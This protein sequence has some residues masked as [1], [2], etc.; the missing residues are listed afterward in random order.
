MKK[1]MNQSV[2]TYIINGASLLALLFMVFSLVSYGKVSG[3]LNKANEDRFNLT[4]NA[5][6]FMNGS[7]YLTNEV[8]AFAATGKQEH[9]DN[10]FNEINNLKN[11][12]LGV[13][14]MKEIGITKEEQEMI[15]QMSTLSNHLVPLEEQAMKNVKEG[16][17]EDAVGYVYGKEY[18]SA[19][20]EIN[21]IKERF[22]A[23]LD[24]RASEEVKLLT[25]EADA[26]EIRILF[27]LA[28][29]GIMQLFSM[30]VTRF[31]ILR[32]VITVKNQMGEISRGNLSAEFNLTS[33]TSEIGMLVASIHETKRELKK[34]IKD[35][36]SK[37]AQMAKG[38]MNLTIGDDYRGEFK[39]IQDAMREILDALNAALAQ[40]NETAE[41][42]AEESRRMAT[43]AQSLSSGTVEQA[44][45]VEQLSSSVQDIS[46][47][48]T[49]TSKDADDARRHSEDAASELEVCDQKMEALTTAMSDISKASHEIGGIIK[50]IEDISSQTNILALNASVE[51]AHAGDAGRGF[52]VVADEVQSLANKSSE[53]AQNI[54]ALIENSMQLVQ[55]GVSLSAETMESL[56]VVVSSS[57]KSTEMIER[58]AESAKQQVQSLEQ[59]SAGM[60]QIS[61]VVQNNAATAE[62]SAASASE[63]ESHAENLKISVQKFRLR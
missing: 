12:D 54:S 19:I 24:K 34:Y 6:R 55:Y 50:T 29:V 8:R 28:L 61:E 62:E 4:Y 53:S 45:A 42:V 3:E 52:S 44:E 59:V 43:G 57:Q 27:A 33:N 2:L 58:I 22:L 47:Q 15:E 1:A 13:A 32:P 36:D 18:S 48:V 40:I 35:I 17:K 63:L 30:I 31:Q 11:R 25:E 56:S 60:R 10:Y 46:R 9:Y 37:L 20:A 38:N 16:K 5:N 39:P 41:Q 51:A 21:A 23:D 26:I 7:S 14:A 49:H